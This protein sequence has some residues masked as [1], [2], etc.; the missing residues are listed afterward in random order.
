MHGAIEH[1]AEY[2][3]NVDYISSVKN[4]SDG[5]VRYYFAYKQEQMLMK[6]DTPWITNQPNL[7]VIK[8]QDYILLTMVEI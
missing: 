5:E 2:Q 8:I 4:T 7:R 3:V 6:C 1:K